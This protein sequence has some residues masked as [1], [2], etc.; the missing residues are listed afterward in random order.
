MFYVNCSHILQRMI[1][2]LTLANNIHI[3]IPGNI[4][5]IVQKAPENYFLFIHITAMCGKVV[6]QILYITLILVFKFLTTLTY[7]EAAAF[8]SEHKPVL[9]TLCLLTD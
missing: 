4:V 6:W 3:L 5:H 1:I 7:F 9:N 2:F 8:S